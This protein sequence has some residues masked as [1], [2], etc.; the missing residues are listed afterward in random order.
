MLPT[1]ICRRIGL[2][3]SIMGD[4]FDLFF[5][6]KYITVP[7]TPTIIIPIVLQINVTETFETKKYKYYDKYNDRPMNAN[8]CKVIGIRS[9]GTYIINN[10]C[11]IMEFFQCKFGIISCSS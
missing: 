4:G 10:W 8:S 3:E 7:I 2:S 11:S 6:T 9:G 5:I 1:F